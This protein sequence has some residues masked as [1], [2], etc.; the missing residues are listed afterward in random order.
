MGDPNIERL[1]SEVARLRDA[2]Q[3]IQCRCLARSHTSKFAHKLADVADDA[4]NFSG[5][6]PSKHTKTCIDCV[7]VQPLESFYVNR[8]SGDGRQSRCKPCDNKR[9]M[10]NYKRGTGNA[11]DVVRNADGS[12]TFVDR[13]RKS[14]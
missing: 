13:K 2:L 6:A 14:A 12:L 8:Q 9:R 11:R 1:E 3:D 5:G 7:V 10:G 4:L